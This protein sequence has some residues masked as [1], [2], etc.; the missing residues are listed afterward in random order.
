MREILAER[1]C[2][3]TSIEPRKY[4]QS[5]GIVLGSDLGDSGE[6]IPERDGN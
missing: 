2:L 3:L 1:S 4:Q 5:I 6:R